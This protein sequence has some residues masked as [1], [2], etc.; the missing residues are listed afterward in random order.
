VSSIREDGA[1]A[2]RRVTNVTLVLPRAEVEALAHAALN[3]DL[4]IALLSAVKGAP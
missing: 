3:G 1:D 2:P 4:T